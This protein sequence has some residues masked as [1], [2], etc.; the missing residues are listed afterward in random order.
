[1]KKILSIILAVLMIA[2]TIPFAFAADDYVAKIT[3]NGET[4]YYETFPDISKDY[5]NT[6]ITV[7]LLTDVEYNPASTI[8]LGAPWIINFNGHT[9]KT[10]GAFMLGDSTLTLNGPGNLI[11]VSKSDLGILIDLGTLIIGGD[12]APSINKIIELRDVDDCFIKFETTSYCKYL[13]GVNNPIESYPS[14]CFITAD[15]GIELSTNWFALNKLSVCRALSKTDEGICLVKLDEHNTVLVEAQAPTCT[16]IGWEAYEYCTAC[17]YSTYK[18]IP[19]SHNIVTVD[20]KAPTCTEIGWEAY[21]YCT[22]CDYTTYVEIPLNGHTPLEAVT[23]NEVA[24]KCGVAGSYDLVVY[25]AC[26]EELDRDTV[27]VDA[28]IH[29][30]TKYAVT[31]EAKCGVAGKEVATCD[32]GCG[33]TDEKA[34]A[35]LTHKDADGD[36]KCDNGCGHEFEKPAPE[37]PTPDTPD[38]PEDETCADCGKVHTNFFSEIIC[39]F[40]RIINFIKNLFA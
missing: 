26:G 34:I 2:T 35:A 8:E 39:F 36:Y 11:R 6:A 33:A 12:E 38:E 9:M 28:L 1:M 16:T 4:T 20:A 21:E 14:N 7:D 10:S 30:F 17:K 32:N 27:A 5:R 15:E 19:A 22:E 37:E 18:A 40:T 13:I 24:P 25:C 3:A 23:E 29:S 31:E